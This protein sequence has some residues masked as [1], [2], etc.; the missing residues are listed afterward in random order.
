MKPEELIS[1]AQL[2]RQRA[3]APYSGFM[4]GAALLT[5]SGKLY[6]GCNIENASYG[7]TVC[8][9]RVA[10]FQAVSDGERKF[11]SL[12]VVTANGGTPCGACRQVL[13]EF[14]YSMPVYI[15]DES[16]NYE[17]YTVKELLPQPFLPEHLIP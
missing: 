17:T 10:V 5:G 6:T 8:A 12:A 4:V 15:A 1:Q 14:N 16:G 9:E 2:A 7:L 3:Y 13:A 11:A